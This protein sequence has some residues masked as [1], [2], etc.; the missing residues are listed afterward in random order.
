MYFLYLHWNYI[1]KQYITYTAKI[2][3]EKKQV[4]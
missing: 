3:T 1:S 2:L 4:A